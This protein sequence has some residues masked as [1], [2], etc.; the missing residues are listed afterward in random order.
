MQFADQHFST[1]SYISVPRG[2]RAGIRQMFANNHPLLLVN[3]T[4]FPLLSKKELAVE[5]GV[6]KLG[7]EYGRWKK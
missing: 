1:P 7:S 2:R 6:C 5:R 4:T 3:Q